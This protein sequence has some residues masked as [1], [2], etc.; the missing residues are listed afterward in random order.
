MNNLEVKWTGD[1][2]SLCFGKWIIKYKGIELKVPEERK[3]EHMNTDGIYST[4]T[5]YLT[6]ESDVY[7][8]GLEYNDW[9]TENVDWV[10][11]MFNK[12]EIFPNGT[13][14]K[15]LYEKIQEQDWRSGSC[16]GCI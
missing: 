10:T 4:I 5:D 13:L 12:S 14:I 7:Q 6:E 8:D 2:P 3:Y 15:E 11:D 1:Y 16:G 9:I